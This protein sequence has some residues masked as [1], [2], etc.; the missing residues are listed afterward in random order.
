MVLT[1]GGFR[2]YDQPDGRFVYVDDGM[3]DQMPQ[4]S[5]PDVVG[6]DRTWPRPFRSTDLRVSEV[7]AC[8]KGVGRGSNEIG[9]G[10]MARQL[11]LPAQLRPPQ[12]V[13]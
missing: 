11:A 2:R 5:G 1:R 13:V 9:K 10:R 6:P 4:V 8:P 3:R 7:R 12:F